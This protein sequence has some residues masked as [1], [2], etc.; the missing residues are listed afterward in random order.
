MTATGEANPDLVITGAAGML[1]SD[2]ADRARAL[3]YDPVCLDLPAFDICSEDAVREALREADTVI[4]CA[5]YTN[6]DG[7]EHEPDLAR[8]VNAEATGLLGQVA[9]EYGVY[10][11]HVSTDFVFD[12]R[13][14]RPYH[15]NDEPHPL[16]VY[17][18]TKL[19][20]ETALRRS[21][22]HCC[23]VRVQWTYGEHGNNFVFKLLDRART[24][25][26]VSM[27]VDQVG[28]P[29]WTVDAARVLLD[30]VQKRVS[31][32]YHYAAAGFASRYDVAAFLLRES[33]LDCSLEPCRTSDFKAAVQRPLNSRF[34][35]SK[36][37]AVLRNP[38]PPWKD[39]LRC[40]L[41][42]LRKET[43]ARI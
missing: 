21:G 27:V 1:G 33:G 7:A 25:E 32:L 4:N 35:G 5:A 6:V 16:N 9:A 2:V 18:R 43:N 29:T 22:A 41:D 10:V 13:K 3:G 14:D 12:G 42:N 23:I 24:A 17:G 30:L 28:S 20:G 31:G 11:V 37:E 19:D 38:R 8:A 36:I 26:H 15:E 40:F 39:A 34:N